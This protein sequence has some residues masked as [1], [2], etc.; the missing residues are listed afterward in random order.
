MGSYL[1]TD[2][3]MSRAWRRGKRYQKKEL[4]WLAKRRG[5]EMR[6]DGHRLEVYNT[7]TKLV[8]ANFQEVSDNESIVPNEKSKLF[9]ALRLGLYFMLL[10]PGA[11][12]AE[13]HQE[14]V[15]AAVLMGEAWGEGERGM[16]AIA[17]VISERSRDNGWTPLRV[18]TEHTGRVH[19]FSCLNGTNGDRLVEHYA[20]KRGYSGALRLAGLVCRHPDRLPGLTLHATHFTRTTEKPW[21][22]KDQKAVII[23]GRH[24]FYRLA[25]R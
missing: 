17:E 13:T 10:L 20:G 14:R 11:I 6:E 18:V 21:W 8:V 24:S 4:R 15:V 2:R 7:K 1:L 19:A 12:L 23:I 16:T 22:A 9:A 5:L 25:R 3:K